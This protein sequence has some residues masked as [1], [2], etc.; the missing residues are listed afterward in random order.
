MVP[1]AL[2]DLEDRISNQQF[3]TFNQIGLLHYSVREKQIF[4]ML[5]LVMENYDFT[6]TEQFISK[7]RP[8]SSRKY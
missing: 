4:R 2:A 5:W 8:D 3:L 6:R 1:P 7:A